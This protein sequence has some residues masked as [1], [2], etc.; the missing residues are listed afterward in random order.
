MGDGGRVEK[1]VEDAGPGCAE[2]VALG[3]S[4]GRCRFWVRTGLARRSWSVG[5]GLT[6][7]V[8]SSAS[9]S[10]WLACIG[11]VAWPLNR[12]STCFW[13]N[14]ILHQ[15]I[16]SRS[17]GQVHEFAPETRRRDAHRDVWKEN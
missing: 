1:G 15:C 14:S 11:V 2:S 13:T 5:K 10:C 17:W 9:R 6:V 12:T 4:F 3:S 16:W 8:P 7:L